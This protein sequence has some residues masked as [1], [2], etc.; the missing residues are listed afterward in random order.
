[1]KL[2]YQ[3]FDKSGRQV[4]DTI[5]AGTQAE[6]GEMLRRRGLYVTDLQTGEDGTASADAA[7]SRRRPRPRRLKS[8]ALLTSQLHVLVSCGTPLVEALEALARQTR[9]P[10]I[11]GAVADLERRVQEGSSLSAAVEAHPRYFGPFYA[12]LVG[13]GEASGNLAGMLQ[14]LAETLR[15]QVHVRNALVGALIYPAL[16]TAVSVGVLAV[17]FTVVIP[18]FGDL[19]DTLN[20]PLPPS[21]AALVAVSDLLLTYWYY[22]VPAVGVP[23]VA[24]AIYLATGSGRRMLQTVML[25]LPQIGRI[26]RRFATARIV[27]LLGVLLDANVPIIDAIRLTRRSIRH[28]RY[29][30][31]LAET[32]DAVTRGETMSSVWS[33]SHLVSPSVQEIV[34]NGERSGQVSTMLLSVADFLD[35]E[36]ELTVRSLTSI[37]EPIILIVMGAVVGVV[38]VSLFMPLFDLTSM[39]QGGAP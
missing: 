22:V 34:R 33:R 21:T 36:N 3:A 8:V 19:F 7:P 1:V 23:V 11:R 20:V 26:V 4:T 38:A 30:R 35:D 12:S 10:Q 25:H 39:T 31:L 28:H 2:A 15:K 32:E 14:R 29:D 18:R 37:V 9:D 27:R 17:M 16:L 5:E 24:L 6:A 13:A